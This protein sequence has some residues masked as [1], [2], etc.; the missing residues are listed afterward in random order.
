[1]YCS[2]GRKTASAPV[3]TNPLWAYNTDVQPLVEAKCSPCHI[4]SKGGN[5][6]DLHTYTSVKEHIDDII[7]RVQLNPGDKG[8]MPLKHPKLSDSAIKVFK[9]WKANGMVETK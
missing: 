1:M 5:K 3:V 9:S 6:E 8:Y 7:R 2:P 4:P